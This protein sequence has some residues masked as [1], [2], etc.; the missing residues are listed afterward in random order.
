M[1]YVDDWRRSHNCI[2]SASHRTDQPRPQGLLLD[3]FQN[4][5]LSEE[6]PLPKSRHFENRL[7]EGPEMRLTH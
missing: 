2:E 3:D 6:D 5:G 1:G 4:G 7:G